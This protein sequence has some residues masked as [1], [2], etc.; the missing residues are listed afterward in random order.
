MG[1]AAAVLAAAD[2]AEA[3]GIA[4]LAAPAD[5]LEVTASYLSERGLPGRLM[6]RLCV[7]SWSL[8]HGER[9]RRLTP[10]VRVRELEVPV[11][12][13]HPERDRRVTE[14]HALRLAAAARTEPEIVEGAAHTDVLAHPRT[15]ELLEAFVGG[16]TER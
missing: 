4:L 15:A 9:H 6:V 7:P 12:V 16:L 10:D 14:D 8:R 2:G 3:A 1:G 5:V 13:V 11:L